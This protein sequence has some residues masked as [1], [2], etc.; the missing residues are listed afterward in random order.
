MNIGTILS[1]LAGKPVE[2]LQK[3]FK[4]QNVVRTMPNTPATVGEGMT[5]WYAANEVPE[6]IVQMTKDI[7]RCAGASSSC[8]W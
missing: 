7:L 6:D 5:V 8:L 3:I 2:D 4:T 1:I